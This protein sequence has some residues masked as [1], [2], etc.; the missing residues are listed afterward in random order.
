MR[1]PRVRFHSWTW[2]IPVLIAADLAALWIWATR[3]PRI[4]TDWLG[5]AGSPRRGPD[6]PPSGMG[7]LG[8]RAENSLRLRVLIRSRRIVLRRGIHPC[9][10]PPGHDASGAAIREPD[11]AAN[12]SRHSAWRE[13]SPFATACARPSP[14][15]RSWACTW[16]GRFTAGGRGGCGAC[17]CTA[18]APQQSVRTRIERSCNRN[19]SNSPSSWRPTI[20]NSRS[21]VYPTSAST[22]QRRH[23]PQ[24]AVQIETG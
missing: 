3:P 14:R 5:L 15:S 22:G 10:H 1:L 12:V 21:S 20:R 7:A 16:A 6:P 24:T 19:K 8:E 9:A 23:M 4:Y 13:S 17:T 2:L 11:L 18:P